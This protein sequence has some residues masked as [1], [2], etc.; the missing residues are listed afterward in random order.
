M[1]RLSQLPGVYVPMFYKASYHADG[2]L[3]SFSPTEKNVPSI[4]RKNLVLDLEH[5]SYP[6]NIIVPYMEI[7]HDRINIE[8]L[9]GCTRGCRFCQAGM[10]YRPVRERSMDR[11]L[12]LADCLVSNTGYEEI[13]LS[14]LS[15]GDY[16]QLPQL[17]HEMM[18]RYEKRR[19]ALSLPSLRL[20]SKLKE[21]L[22]ETQRVRKT[23]LTYAMEA[24]TQRLRD[25]INKGITENDLLS[26]VSDAFS[27]GWSSIKL[28]FMFGLP[29]ETKE[30]LNG[31]ADLASKVV[32]KYFETPKEMRARGLR[33]NCSASC[34]VP[35][36]FT[37]FQ[38]E[39]QDT[40]SVFREKQEYLCHI[41]HIKGVEFNWHT[42][43]VSFLEAVFARGDR[44]VAEVLETAW[45][46]GC[47]FDG[48]A[49]QFRFD[50]WMQAFDS[51]GI[52]P[53][54]YANR[55]RRHGELFPWSFIDAGV[56]EKYLQREH[57]RAYVGLITPDCRN[58]CQGC[59]LKR[60]EGACTN[61]ENVDGV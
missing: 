44:R 47:R 41:M 39:P 38:W 19:V 6:E 35:K 45:K 12:E 1:Y 31:I 42:P 24:G 48:W 57:E 33:V 29:T 8:V 61:N 22:E 17:A 4:V 53:G 55:S 9:R 16:S 14:S 11:I 52:D 51:C 40:L 5:A 20:D 54:F 43:E 58:G 34:F 59:G 49:D 37:P 23:S 30:D 18:E 46:N 36:P 60:F 15:T 10:L 25:V 2:T 27:G 56:T 32:R 7:V 28:Y 26:S 3:A 50:V 21:T 13:T